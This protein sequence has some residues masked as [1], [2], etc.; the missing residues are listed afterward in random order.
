M[1]HGLSCKGEHEATVQS[2]HDMLKRNERALAAA[3]RNILL[4]PL[5]YAFMGLVFVTW[6][7]TSPKG[8]R[9]FTFILGCGF[10]V[11]GGAVYRQARKSL[12]RRA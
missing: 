7:L 11:F 9:D 2:Y 5:F 6:G 10:L 8:V 12:L 1:G 3:P 4:M